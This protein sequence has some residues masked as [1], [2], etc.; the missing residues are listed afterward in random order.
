[1][2]KFTDLQKKIRIAIAGSFGRMGKDLIKTFSKE[3]R[4]S[5]ELFLN[6]DFK[7]KSQ[8][9]LL[10]NSDQFDLLIDFTSPIGTMQNVVLCKEIKKPIIIGT[11]GLSQRNIRYIVQFS[12]YIPILISENFSFG[13]NLLFKFFQEYSE[14]LNNSYQIKLTETHHKN[15]RDFPSGTSIKIEK[16]LSRKKESERNFDSF[17]SSQKKSLHQPLDKNK[18]ILLSSTRSHLTLSEHEVTFSRK[19]EK[20]KIRHIVQN[21]K[22]FCEGVMRS[23]FWIIRK[24]NGLYH[25][26]EVFLGK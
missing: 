5:I 18:K 2:K 26:Q 13:M 1:M 14:I 4:F 21:R 12:R 15:K 8:I 23:C 9:D 11:T 19:Y 20:I 6:K 7:I 25:S 17:F 10:K 3:P 16:I 24:K 22:V